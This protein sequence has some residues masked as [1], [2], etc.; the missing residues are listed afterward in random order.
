MPKS[1]L[2]IAD[3]SGF[4]RFVNETEVSHSRHIISELLEGLIDKNELGM[5]VAEIEGDAVLFYNYGTV[6]TMASLIAQCQSMF[7]EFHSHL[8]NYRH[9]RICHCGACRTAQ[10]LSVKFIAHEGEFSFVKVKDFNK[11]YG[12]DVILVHKLLK[13]NV[14]SDEYILTTNGLL[15]GV[16]CQ[17]LK[18]QYPWVKVDVAS[19]H[20]DDI[21]KVDYSFISLE[22]LNEQV[23][24]K[25]SVFPELSQN[26]IVVEGVIDLDAPT[27][28][29]LISNF[30]FRDEWNDSPLRFEYEENRVN[31]MGTRHVCVFENEALEFETVVNDFGPNKLVYGERLSNYQ[32]IQEATN[33]F[34]LE[35]TGDQTQLRIESHVKPK[36]ALIKVFSVFYRAIFR[37]N[38]KKAH[39]NIGTAA[40]RLRFRR[41]SSKKTS[42]NGHP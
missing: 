25:T 32:F 22:S 20:Y 12:A 33:Y 29:E 8:L 4:T 42:S 3:I 30:D 13:N 1:L 39:T 23:E 5:E 31:R 7:L 37:K 2:F 24:V 35:E 38:L 11:P 41:E 40:H 15:E 14:D 26:P 16:N 18:E 21:G 28:F 19:T 27:L 6:P 10:D 36:N 9:K 17:D 34:I